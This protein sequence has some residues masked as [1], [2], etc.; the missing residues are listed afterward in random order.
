MFIT[1]IAPSTISVITTYRCTAACED[2]C[3]ECSPSIDK[4]LTYDEIREFIINA[5]QEYPSIKLIVFTGGEC[6]ILKEKLFALISMCT[7]MG[8]ITRCVTN[9]YWAKNLF[10]ARDY[11]QKLVDS[12]IG[13]I[14][15]STGKS[16]QKYVYHKT[17]VNAVKALT[18]FGIPTLITVETDSDSS[19]CF[20]RLRAESLIQEELDKDSPGIKIQVNS[21]VRFDKQNEIRQEEQTVSSLNYGCDNL[22]DTV[23]VTPDKEIAACCGITMSHID[24]MNLGHMSQVENYGKQIDDFL[25]IWIKTEG[26][27]Q[28]LKHLGV[29]RD[30]LM[31][32]NHPCQAC[33]ILY[34]DEEIKKSLIIN[35]NSHVVRVINKVKLQELTG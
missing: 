30:K 17:I 18:E 34:K 35:Y 12:G 28:I 32:I 2:C 10:R 1:N 9:A 27:F 11:C 15:I 19:S 5:S 25:K 21:W 26:A 3:F 6:F 16:H 13:E 4:T 8:F 22:F 20:E 31:T 14:N 23:V 33:A 24:E 29:S 7:E